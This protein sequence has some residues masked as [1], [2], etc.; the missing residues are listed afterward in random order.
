MWESTRARQGPDSWQDKE[1]ARKQ[2][3]KNLEFSDAG[4]PCPVTLFASSARFFLLDFLPFQAWNRDL[5]YGV[6]HPCIPGPPDA[7]VCDAGCCAW[8]LGKSPD[9]RTTIE[10][11]IRISSWTKMIIAQSRL[12]VAPT[13]NASS[14]DEISHLEHEAL[15]V[16][17]VCRNAQ[18]KAQHYG[19]RRRCFARSKPRPPLHGPWKT[20]N[21]KNFVPMTSV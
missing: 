12:G 6:Q 2:S 17:K 5:S 14:K 4:T 13:G 11:G 19:D 1:A 7:I 16:S 3:D 8:V 15:G 9:A 18:P 10:F 20:W 21:M